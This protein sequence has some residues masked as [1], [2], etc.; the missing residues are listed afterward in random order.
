MINFE[1]YDSFFK[2]LNSSYI[3]L[4]IIFPFTKILD[5]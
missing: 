3:L 4:E 1:S 5:I 2:S